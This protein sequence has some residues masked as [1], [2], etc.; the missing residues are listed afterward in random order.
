[1][2]PA[3]LVLHVQSYWA[4]VALL[5]LMLA[6]HQSFSVNVFAIVTDVTPAEKVGSV[7]A[8]GALFGNQ[9]GMAILALAG[10]LLSSGYS[11]APLFDLA[12]CSY[13]LATGWI[14]LLLPVLRPADGPGN[15]RLDPAAA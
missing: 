9:A 10:W 7:T 4:A 11:Y 1:M 8:I 3:P 14:Q 2:L 6:A 13:L 15:A 12:A 5:G